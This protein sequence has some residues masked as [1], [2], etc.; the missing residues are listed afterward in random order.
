M[1]PSSSISPIATEIPANPAEPTLARGSD[2][3]SVPVRP[4]RT[5]K[6]PVWH[7]VGVVPLQWQQVPWALPD[8]KMMSGVSSS[9][10]LPSQLLSVT[11]PTVGVDHTSVSSGYSA[12]T[13][14]HC[15]RGTADNVPGG[16]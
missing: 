7:A 3:T 11:R 16:G 8:T 9:S 13:G 14:P 5:R 6:T 10:T 15:Q 1:L 4:S 2:Q 12:A